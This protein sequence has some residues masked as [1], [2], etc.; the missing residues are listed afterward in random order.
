[1]SA[2][3]ASLIFV[4]PSQEAGETSAVTD[5]C[6]DNYGQ[7]QPCQPEFVNAAFNAKVTATNTCGERGE[8]KYCNIPTTFGAQKTCSYCNA[9]KDNLA[10]PAEYLVDQEGDRTWWQSEAMLEMDRHHINNVNLTIHFGKNIFSI[11]IMKI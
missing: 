1:M 5:P 9:A 2:L 6:T 7:A 10:H 11:I 3:S 8:M 4:A